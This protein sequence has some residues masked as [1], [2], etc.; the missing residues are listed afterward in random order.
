MLSICYQIGRISPKFSTFPG[1]DPG[2]TGNRKNSITPTRSWNS[3]L[4]QY[5]LGDIC[6]GSSDCFDYPY[7]H[8]YTMDAYQILISGDKALLGAQGNRSGRFLP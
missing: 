3:Y 2:K 5:G 7:Y 1:L 6:S 8:S 4:K